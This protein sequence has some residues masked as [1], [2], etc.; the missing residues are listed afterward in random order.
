MSRGSSSS[1][2]SISAAGPNSAAN[3]LAA[4]AAAD[5]RDKDRWTDTR[6]FSDVDRILCRLRNKC[7]QAK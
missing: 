6:L 2:P 5:Q 1:Y 3:P 7:K 4:A